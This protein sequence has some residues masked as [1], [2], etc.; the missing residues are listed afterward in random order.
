MLQLVLEQA[1][2][3]Q[4]DMKIL[5]LQDDVYHCPD[6]GQKLLYVP[7][8]KE[9]ACRMCQGVLQSAKAMDQVVLESILALPEVIEEGLAVE[10]PTCST[11]SDLSDVKTPLSNFAVEWLFHVAKSR[12]HSVT[13]RGVS[14]VG[15]CKVCGSTWFPGPG[16]RDALGKK[17]GNDRRHL[18]RDRL[19]P[20]QKFDYFS[21]QAQTMACEERMRLVARKAEERERKKEKLCQH[22]DSSGHQCTMK[23]MQKKGA[24]YCYKHQPK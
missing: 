13:Y 18:W 12:Y 5:Y 3:L 14:N 20:R 24:A 22:V 9:H 15:H 19:R 17:I 1:M 8:R 23:K 4:R 21:K 7:R 16:E 6:D 11:D 2:H 10:C